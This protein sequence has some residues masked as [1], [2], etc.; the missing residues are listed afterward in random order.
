M[1]SRKNLIKASLVLIAYCS[2]SFGSV[3]TYTFNSPNF[4]GNNS[5]AMTMAQQERGLKAAIDAKQ[6]AKD[7]AA[8]AEIKAAAAQSS[9]LSNSIMSQLN[10]LVAYKIAN[11]IVSSS[12]GD[13]NSF[14]SGDNTVS[15]INT[16]GV[17][18]IV[19]T[20][21]SGTTTLTLPSLN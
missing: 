1:Q 6:A 16:S 19:I 21:P 12:S 5:Y 4:G 11:Q 7:A 20:S 17:L 18:S 2:P 9:A 3:L 8:A 14:Q 10:G 13:S 15:Y